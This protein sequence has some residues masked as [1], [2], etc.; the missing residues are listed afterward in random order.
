MNHLGL[1]YDSSHFSTVPVTPKFMFI[2]S[3]SMLW[4]T[5]S[6]A[7][8]RFI[9]TSAVQFLFSMAHSR[10]WSFLQGLFHS[11]GAIYKQ[12]DILEVNYV[13]HNAH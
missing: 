1:R 6:K 5:I 7:T 4:S 2:T 13:D 11:C 8:E 9:S 3:L 12:T 10:S